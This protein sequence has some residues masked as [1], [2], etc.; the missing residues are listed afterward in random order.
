AIG[1]HEFDYG[2][3]GP[4]VTAH[5]PGDDVF[6]ALKARMAQAKFPM[7]SANIYE[8]DSKLRPDWLPGDG[9]LVIER[10]GIKI[11]IVG[12]NTPQTPQTTMPINVASLRFAPLAPEALTAAKRLREKGA[13]VV[14]AVMHAG[15]KCAHLEDPNDTSS[16]DTQSAE[17]F[18]ML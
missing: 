18:N 1:N 10:K 13:D 2:P 8:H 16:C 11:G 6:G 12:L 15:G 14:I 9:T 4:A 17:V 5:A 3:V 7:L